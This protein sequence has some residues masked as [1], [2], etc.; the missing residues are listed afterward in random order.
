VR[1]A[2][3][4][5]RPCSAHATAP[6]AAIRRRTGV[7]LS[8]QRD[9]GRGGVR[10]RRL[11]SYRGGQR[12]NR[13][14]EGGHDRGGRETLKKGY[15]QTQQRHTQSTGRASFSYR[16]ASIVSWAPLFQLPANKCRT[17]TLQRRV[18]KG[19]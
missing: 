14:W 2:S 1:A 15:K 4:L 13:R 10:M 3:G 19:L 12:E 17:H 8:L 9:R 18:M 6:T 5:L 7:A 11:S 16:R